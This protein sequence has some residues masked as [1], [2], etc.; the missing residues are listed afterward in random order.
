MRLREQ[1]LCMCSVISV[2]TDFMVDVAGVEETRRLH[3]QL[4]CRFWE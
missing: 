1:L 3:E 2:V 4:L